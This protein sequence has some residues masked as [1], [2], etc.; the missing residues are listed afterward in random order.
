MIKWHKTHCE[1]ERIRFGLSHY[2]MY[3]LS[4]AKGAMLVLLLLW[5]F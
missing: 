3:W 2:I 1:N 5:F 4:F